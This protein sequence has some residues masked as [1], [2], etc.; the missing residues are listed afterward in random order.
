MTSDMAFECLLV[1][2]DAGVFT[3]IGRILRDLSI[4]IDVCLSYSKAQERLEQGGCDLIVV[5]WDGEEASDLLLKIWEDP[6]RR[7]PTVVALSPSGERLPGAHIVIKKPVTLESGTQPFKDAYSRMLL[8]HRRYARHAI[9]LPVTATL[10][11][12]RSMRVIVTDIG[13]GGV[14]ISTKQDLA[15]GD[16][17]SFRLQLP[18]A[19]KE[20][21]IHARVL[22]TRDYG[23]IGC[24]FVRIPPVDLTIL[25]DWLKSRSTVKK[26]LTTA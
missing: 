4:S 6:K 17:L 3:T 8:D 13:D 21:L 2:R 19:E 18:S 1:S 20:I 24:D 10:E 22:W 25:R 16:E 5:D 26:P 11:D 12:G 23:R 14:G 15:D 9:M 7:K